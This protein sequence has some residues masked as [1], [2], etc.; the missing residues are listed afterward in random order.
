VTLVGRD[1]LPGFKRLVVDVD[2]PT[3]IRNIWRLV[4]KLG[5]VKA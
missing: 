2:K 4:V 1:P 3:R 5:R